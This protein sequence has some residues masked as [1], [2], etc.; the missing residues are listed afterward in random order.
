MDLWGLKFGEFCLMYGFLPADIVRL[1]GDCGEDCIWGS[2]YEEPLPVW[3]MGVWE[4]MGEWCACLFSVADIWG[5]FTGDVFRSYSFLGS[6]AGVSGINEKAPACGRERCWGY[7]GGSSSM[8][9]GIVQ[10]VLLIVMDVDIEGIV[11]FGVG[12]GFD[13]VQGCVL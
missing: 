4:Y 7:P 6:C 5:D 10:D 1:G 3:D 13:G 9:V 8:A 11:Y 2:L 12:E